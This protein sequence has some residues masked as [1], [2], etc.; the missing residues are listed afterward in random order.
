MSGNVLID[1][2]I[3]LYLLKGNTE[4]ASLLDGKRVFASFITEVEIL[5]YPKITGEEEYKINEFFKAITIVG[6]NDSISLNST[7]FLYTRFWQAVLGLYILRYLP[8]V[9]S[10]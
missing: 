7:L 6:W 3:A 8:A 2:N 9:W 5:S 1:T 10:K 4:L